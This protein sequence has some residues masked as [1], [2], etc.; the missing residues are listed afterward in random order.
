MHWPLYLYQRGLYPE[1]IAASVNSSESAKHFI[2]NYLQ[3]YLY[4][5]L[6]ALPIF[7]LLVLLVIVLPALTTLF[8]A[9]VWRTLESSPCLSAIP[10][11]SQCKICLEAMTNSFGNQLEPLSP[12]W[13]L[14][15]AFGTPSFSRACHLYDTFNPQNGA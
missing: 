2:E 3:P 7:T 14:A 13:S 11:H 5:C 15:S 9:E 4:G 6:R 12:A 1:R 10:S 8:S